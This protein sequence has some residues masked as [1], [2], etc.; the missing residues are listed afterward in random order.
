MPWRRPLTNTRSD[1]SFDVAR[2]WITD[3][4]GGRGVHATRAISRKPDHQLPSRLIDLA[5]E[6]FVLTD[7]CSNTVF[8]SEAYCTLSYCWGEHLKPPWITK[9]DNLQDR[10]TGFNPSEL[11]KT[12]RDAT[13]IAQRLGIRYIWIDAIC[14]GKEFSEQFSTCFGDL[15]STIFPFW[16]KTMSRS[17]RNPPKPRSD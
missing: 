6:Q 5:G 16:V 2:S 17:S 11:P 9:K 1:R 13:I 10:K 14:I 8:A 15:E 7:T 3:C 12:L 4:C